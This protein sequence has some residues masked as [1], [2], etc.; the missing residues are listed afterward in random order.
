VDHS[1]LSISFANARFN[2]EADFSGRTFEVHAD[3]TNA[4]FYYPPDF[5]AVNNTA[6]IDFTGAHIGF[7]PPGKRAWT[8][9]S[10]VPLRLRALRKIAEDTKNH[11]LE[12]DLYIEERK[13]ER[14][15][16][17]RLLWDE[18]K[19]APKELKKTLEGIDEQQREVW[20]N[21]RHKARA[22]NAHVLGIAAKIAQLILHILWIAVMFL[23]WALSNYGRNFLVPAI[24]L[25]LS[26]PFFEWR[27]TEVLARLM[28]KA[29]DVDKY[30]QAVG[31]L[32][33]GNAVPF[34]GPL[35]IDAGIKEI[36]FCPDKAASCLP[37][38]PPEGFQF[39]VIAQNIV[40]II[41][42]FF[43]GLA[44]RNYFKIK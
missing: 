9:D 4:R 15:V 25:G 16:R 11:D 32:A 38:I 14:G 2:G 31:M 17:C 12:R 20:S 28:A 13:A 10:K 6:R 33:H 19:K 34:V 8:K 24:W 7:V 21:S 1:F 43:I 23:Y 30:K 27:Y 29:P 5:D 18:L 41:L 36:L 3:F 44:L 37:P 26:V 42:V 40:S 39:L 22:R 35:T